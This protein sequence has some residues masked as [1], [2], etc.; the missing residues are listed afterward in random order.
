M[1]GSDVEITPLVRQ[2][3]HTVPS[4]GVLTQALSSAVKQQEDEEERHRKSVPE[5]LSWLRSG[6]KS[7]L[8]DTV[9]CSSSL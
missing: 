1:A 5:W 6:E 3:S 4:D 2:W 9:S 8:V 7:E